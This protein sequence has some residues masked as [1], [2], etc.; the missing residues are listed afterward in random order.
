[1]HEPA[2]MPDE[3][4]CHVFEMKPCILV[5]QVC[6]VGPANEITGSNGV[7]IP[8]HGDFARSSHAHPGL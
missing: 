4:T 8:S 5:S 2:N 6:F 7:P 1:M 3:V